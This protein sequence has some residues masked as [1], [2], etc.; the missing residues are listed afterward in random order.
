MSHTQLSCH[1]IRTEID[2]SCKYLILSINGVRYRYRV[3]GNEVRYV[4]GTF[5][6]L[7]KK[8]GDGKALTWLKKKCILV[9]KEE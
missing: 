9:G 8:A 1:I 2:A 5:E 7:K 3:E 6:W 4:V